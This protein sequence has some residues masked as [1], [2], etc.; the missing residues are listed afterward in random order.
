MHVLSGGGGGDGESGGVSVGAGVGDAAGSG[1]GDAAAGVAAA[2]MR[3]A[4]RE[5]K[6]SIANPGKF[7]VLAPRACASPRRV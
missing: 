4:L 5:P 6:G 7:F 1:V 3:A 2:G